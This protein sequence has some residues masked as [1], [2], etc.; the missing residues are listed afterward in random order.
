MTTPNTSENIKKENS[1]IEPLTNQKPKLKIYSSAIQKIDCKAKTLGS[2]NFETSE[3]DIKE[4]L[5]GL[6]H[7]II[8]SPRRQAFKFKEEPSQ[9]KSKIEKLSTPDFNSASVSLSNK[10]LSCE[11]EAQQKMEKVTKL[12][13][14]SLLSAHFDIGDKKHLIL[15]KIDHAGYLD[16]STLRKKSGLPE[17]QR[18]QKCAV[19]P[20]DGETLDPVIIVIDSNP[21]VT[22]YW[23]KHFLELT[24]LS[25]PEKNTV[26]AFTAI[27]KLLKSKVQKFSPSDY[28]TLRNAVVSYFATR[29]QCHFVEMID[30]I[31]SEY[32]PD[33]SSLDMQ[34]L[35]TEAKKLPTIGKGFDTH[36]D[37]VSGVITSK[38]RKQIPLVENV[39][40]R[41]TGE[42]KD[43]KNTFDT[44]IDDD[45]RKFLK[46]FT[47]EGYEAF[48]KPETENVS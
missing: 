42:V 48:H 20:F 7:E 16:E 45:G 46:I 21:T 1:G 44:G 29:P 23:W 3:K 24:P 19:F 32:K 9:T 36:F 28:W 27:E 39:E 15:V 38:I 18:A 25:S 26:S 41:I 10:L 6:I 11:I 33:V 13:E 30:E 31:I 37:I 17:K 5:D 35:A 43:M 34:E 22:E 47:D 12:R 40:L 14:G 2:P 4:Y 8:E